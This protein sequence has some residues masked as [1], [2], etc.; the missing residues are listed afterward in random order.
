MTR[1]KL[2]IPIGLSLLICLV[3]FP[4]I[5]E[6]IY[7]PALPNVAKGLQASPYAVEVTLSIYFFGF[8]LGVLFWGAFSD[9]AGRRKTILI[10]LAICLIS[11]HTCA[12]TQT[13]EGLLT[14]R[15]IQAF[16]VSV[17]SVTTQTM[18]RDLYQ[19]KE[20]AKVFS[21]ISAALAFSPALGPILGGYTSEQ[22]GWRANFWLLFVLGTVLILWSLLSLPETKPKTIIKPTFPEALELAKK[23]ITSR[24]LIGHVLLISATNG[25]LFS[26][27]E[28]APF[29]FIEQLGMSPST[30]GL[31]GL[32][33]ASATIL[34]AKISYRLSERLD[35]RSIIKKGAL[36]TFVGTLSLLITQALGLF[37]LNSPGIHL[38]ILSLFASFLGIGLIIPSSLSI[39]LK[40]Y[41][42]RVGT[43]GSFFGAAY[44]LLVALMTW[45]MSVLHNG[46]VWPLPIILVSL[47]SILLGATRM[48]HQSPQKAII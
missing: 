34:A 14:W 44:Y 19:G 33:I 31:F 39:A 28:E 1:S 29:I 3:G 18:L 43:A 36:V 46:T 27:Y 40:D 11:C 7:T 47:S 5:S 25:I 24:Q 41:Q 15:F 32:L 8:A 9:W 45:S 20:R 30:Y 23:M 48:V 26:F 38:I 17:G 4:Q 42:E 35:P 10:G 6:T 2:K 16:G 37:Q 21:I 12:T 22:L 13:I